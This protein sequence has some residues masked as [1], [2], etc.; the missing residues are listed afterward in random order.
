MT[1]D[2]QT[3]LFQNQPAPQQDPRVIVVRQDPPAPA[4]PKPEYLTREQALE[5]VE[6][7]RKEEKDKLY[8]TQAD[9]AKR[10]KVFEDE[11]QTLVDQQEAE[12]LAAE[13]AERVRLA[14]EQ[15]A[16]ERLEAKEAEWAARFEQQDQAIAAQQAVYE[17]ERE[18]QGLMQ[19]RAQRLGE[20]QDEID[21]RFHDFVRGDTVEEIEATLYDVAV[22]TQAIGREVQ[23]SLAAQGIMPAGGPP[24]R[25]AA[26]P[27]P[28]TSGPGFTPDQWMGNPQERTLTADDIRNMPMSDFVAQREQ[29]LAAASKSVANKGLYGG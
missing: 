23:E 18:L 25:T 11:R 13:E 5:L 26:P 4:E 24:Q 8:E 19:Y 9:L 2:N 20:L 29:L 22:R 3:G 10:L 28:V 12:R 14:S 1:I 6:A 21:P 15:T 16:L 27:V 7:A 17:R